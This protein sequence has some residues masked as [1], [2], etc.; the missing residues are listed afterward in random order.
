[1]YGKALN[2]MFNVIYRYNSIL[3]ASREFVEKINK[4]IRI[5][6]VDNDNCD[7]R[8]LNFEDPL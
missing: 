2:N 7:R 1:M 3:N 6:F 8:R 5:L 4:K